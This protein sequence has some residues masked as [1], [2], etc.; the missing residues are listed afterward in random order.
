MTDRLSQYLEILPWLVARPHV[1]IQEFMAEF[2][3]TKAQANRA[4]RTLTFVGPDQGGG[5]LVDIDFEDGFIYVRNAQNFDRPVSLNRL[6][7]SSLLG[8]LAYLKAVAGVANL[9]R[10]DALIAK[11]S[12]AANSA[13]APFEVVG[14]QVNVVVVSALKDAIEN[15]TRLEIK[16][17]DG[18]G[19]VTIR[20]IEPQCIEALN[21]LL[22]V[23][24]WCQEASGVRTFR[25]DRI[26]EVSPSAAPSTN[27][28]G[29]IA[30]V[31]IVGSQQAT[32]LTTIES[33][34]DFSSAHILSQK[35]Q[36]DGRWLVELKVGSIS[37]LAG[38]I[39]ANGGEMQ[40]IEPTE[41]R[42]EVLN[43]ANKWLESSGNS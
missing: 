11:I 22:Y 15:K 40:A 10:I 33:L 27:V 7:A 25:V 17:S 24:A 16:Y 9:A 39:L 18:T 6:E 31:D 5:G 41:L 3:L 30:H 26:M 23:A 28:S 20:V 21:D 2:N 43:R 36:A 1:S 29:V 35:E 19:K 12:D 4:L 34:E 8:G 13:G 42:Q 32:V 14:L 38:L 37:W